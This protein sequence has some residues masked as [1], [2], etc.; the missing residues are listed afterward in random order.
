V[1]VLESAG[2]LVEVQLVEQ[3]AVTDASQ[4]VRLALAFAERLGESGAF[5]AS[6]DLMERSEYL[7]KV[8]RDGQVEAHRVELAGLQRLVRGPTPIAL[9]DVTELVHSTDCWLDTDASAGVARAVDMTMRAARMCREQAFQAA[10]AES[11][12]FYQRLQKIAAAAVY[13]VGKLKPLPRQ[14]WGAADPGG[15]MIREGRGDDWSRMVLAQE[16]FSLVHQAGQVMRGMG[17]LG[18][19]GLLNGPP[20]LAYAYKRWDLALNGESE[21]RRL[22]PGLRLAHALREQWEP[23]LWTA[24]DVPQQPAMPVDPR[25]RRG[26]IGLLAGPR[27]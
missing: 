2:Q 20:D 7:G 24:T 25:T 15:Q 6:R 14:V 17:G 4:Q 23:G 13:E 22:Q 26:L 8:V 21:L 3:L 11:S 27:A 19:A 12:G 16:K 9:S 18:A 10:V 5:K 1:T